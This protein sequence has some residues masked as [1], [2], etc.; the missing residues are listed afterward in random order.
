[1]TNDKQRLQEFEALRALA[2]LLLL[3]LHSEVFALKVFGY[4]LGPAAEF[5][6]AF[7]LGSCFFF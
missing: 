4:E 5:V 2:I 3:A 1:M 7:L 6:A